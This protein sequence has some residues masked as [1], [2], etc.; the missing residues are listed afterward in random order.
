MKIDKSIVNSF[1]NKQISKSE[2]SKRSKKGKS[3]L[4]TDSGN[5]TI[6]QL[7][8]Y[9]CLK[10]KPTKLMPKNYTPVYDPEQAQANLDVTK[11][12]I[13]QQPNSTFLAQANSNSW[14]VFYLL[15]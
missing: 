1:G 6:V 4:K 13:L 2:V 12:Q 15:S 9:F 8:D 7:S 5:D 11:L 3:E 10:T 14:D